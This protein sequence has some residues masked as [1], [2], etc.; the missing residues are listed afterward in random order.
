MSGSRAPDPVVTPGRGPTS[1]RGGGVLCVIAYARRSSRG[2]PAAAA[3]PGGHERSPSKKLWR[4]PPRG[5]CPKL[6]CGR[7]DSGMTPRSPTRFLAGTGRHRTAMPT[8]SQCHV[9]PPTAVARPSQ[10]SRMGRA[11]AQRAAGDGLERLPVSTGPRVRRRPPARGTAPGSSASGPGPRVGSG[12]DT[13]GTAPR[14]WARG[15]PGPRT[16]QPPRSVP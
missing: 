8:A 15:C 14:W 12:A 13:S 5:D 3:S 16:R 6:H 4:L 1:A 10:C 9:R 7:C 2:K 11:T